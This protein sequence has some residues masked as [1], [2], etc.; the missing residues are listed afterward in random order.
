M[1]NEALEEVIDQI[2]TS[3][4]VTIAGL[5]RMVTELENYASSLA[6]RIELEST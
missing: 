2:S 1:E 5:K 4:D 3:L 6:D